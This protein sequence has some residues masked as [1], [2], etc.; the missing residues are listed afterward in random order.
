[1]SFSEVEAV[2]PTAIG[3]I[4]KKTGKPNP[5]QVEGYFLRTSTISDTKKRNGIGYIHHF[6]TKDGEA[7]VWGKTDMDRKLKGV[8]P[9]VMV[10]ITATGKTKP[11]PNGDM[12]LY[13]VQQDVNNSIP[14]SN[15]LDAPGVETEYA[16]QRIM[17][18]DSE[19]S[20]EED[21]SSYDEVTPARG[22]APSHPAAIDSDKAAKVKALLNP[23]K[24]A[25]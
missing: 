11:T 25:R 12:V 14:V 1:M 15:D 16:G 3:G 10:R 6:Q 22:F 4:N 8:R 21:S 19:D 24:S 9:G 7:A 23:G 20:L 13:V 2:I 5:T 17:E 18:D